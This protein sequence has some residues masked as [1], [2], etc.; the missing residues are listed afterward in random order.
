MLGKG[1]DA[2]KELGGL[3]DAQLFD[4]LH[5]YMTGKT[6]NTSK[7]SPSASTT[8]T[9]SRTFQPNLDCPQSSQRQHREHKQQQGRATQAHYSNG[10]ANLLDITT[11]AA[12]IALGLTYLKTENRR[13]AER[14][15]I[16]DTTKP[17]LNYVRPDFLLLRVVAKNLILW[18]S[19]TPSQQWIDEQLPSFMRLSQT[20]QGSGY[21]SKHGNRSSERISDE[22]LDGMNEQVMNQAKYN[23]IAGACLCLGLRFAGSQDPKAF[24]CLLGHFDVFLKLAV[25]QV[26]SFQDYITRSAV[27]ICIDVIATA[28]AMV[29]AGTGHEGLYKRLKILHERIPF[30][31]GT[32]GIG[33][34]GNH[35]ASH[36]ALGLLFCGLGRYTLKTT[37][38]AIAGLL[39]SFYPF[40]PVDSEDQRSHLQAFRHLW[41]MGLD[42]RW[43]TPF[44]CDTKKPCQ[45]PLLLTTTNSLATG[46]Q[47]TED[48]DVASKD[49]NNNNGIGNPDKIDDNNE[50]E[51]DNDFGGL[52]ENSVSKDPHGLKRRHRQCRVVAPSVVPN[53]DTLCSIQLDSS[54]YYPLK[55]NMQTKGDYQQVIRQSGILFVQRKR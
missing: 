36:M 19:I 55:I 43:L 41:V 39:C 52:G 14:L 50:N 18:Q 44:D 35:M 11:P 16:C 51:C 42:Q 48:E 10:I 1:G 21:N 26:S 33:N 4:T 34:Y 53:Y 8:P 46:Y 38:E 29:M 24:G 5:N 23:I 13:I 22:A 27:W 25:A 7:S 45:V 49:D 12:T 2:S 40:Y 32:T 30:G 9:P 28:A 6:A 54:L 15:D 31:A 47:D 20:Q 3:P 37:N 17:Y